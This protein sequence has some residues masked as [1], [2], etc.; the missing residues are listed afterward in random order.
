M[1]QAAA[2]TQGHEERF[3]SAELS[4]IRGEL[5]LGKSS[6]NFHD[7]ELCFQ[8][9]QSIAREQ[10]AKT[11][12]LRASVSLSRLWIR[13]SRSKEAMRLLEKICGWFTEGLGTPDFAEAK[14]L[15]QEFLPVTKKTH[16]DTRTSRN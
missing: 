9:A 3:F 10:K 6:Q 14:A 13:M 5:L 1:A 11:L 12:E 16:R 2:I 7:V 15:M 8:D 4:R